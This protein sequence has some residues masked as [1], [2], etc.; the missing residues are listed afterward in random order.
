[1]MTLSKEQATHNQNVRGMFV[2]LSIST[3]GARKLD[4]DVSS[5]VAAS[6][7]V[8]EHAGNY[9]KNLLAHTDEYK[10]V[11]KAT[12]YARTICHYKHTLPHLIEGLR[13]LPNAMYFDYAAEM[14]IAIREIN[15][16][17]NDFIAAYPRL[18]AER[19]ATGNGLYKPDDFPRVET[20]KDKFSFRIS[21]IPIPQADSFCTDGL[22]DEVDELSKMYTEQNDQGMLAANRDIWKR[23][24]DVV[25][26]TVDA[27]ERYGEPGEKRKKTFRDTLVPN[28]KNVVDLAGNLNFMSDP[29]IEATREAILNDLTVYDCETLRA[30]ELIRIET[31]QKADQI[32]SVMSDFI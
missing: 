25:K 31:K 10:A 24:H 21:L 11:V 19:I 28:L 12:N 29:T 3:W 20:L 13:I 32:L 22:G 16:A 14:N 2:A 15:N 8:D 1:M 7:G 27:L 30:S 23:M 4:K 9:N 6:H 5:E 17:V 18:V 26:A